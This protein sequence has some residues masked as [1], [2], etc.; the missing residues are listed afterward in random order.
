MRSKKFAL[1]A[2]MIA[3]GASSLSAQTADYPPNSI[4]C[5]AFT[6]HSNGTWY[7]RGSTTFDIGTMKGVTISQSEIGPGGMNLGGTNL[8]IVIEHKCGGIRS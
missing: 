6:K 3:M 8:Y 2:S 4:D 7:V 5:A 1:A